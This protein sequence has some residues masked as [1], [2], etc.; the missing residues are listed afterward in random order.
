MRD[1]IAERCELITPSDVQSHLYDAL[2]VYSAAGCQVAVTPQGATSVDDQITLTFPAG[3][4]VEP[5]AVQRVWA[6]GISGDPIIHGYK[7]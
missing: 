3:A 6:A 1:K 5:L 2:R 4:I 7:G